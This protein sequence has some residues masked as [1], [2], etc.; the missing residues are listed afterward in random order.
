MSNEL[1]IA[2]KKS[3]NSERLDDKLEQYPV[4]WLLKKRDGTTTKTYLDM[5][6]KYILCMDKDHFNYTSSPKENQKLSDLLQK[7]EKVVDIVLITVFQWFGS[8]VGIYKIRNLL[9]GLTELEK[10]K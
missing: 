2:N 9:K 6:K 5:I 7:N 10:K 3:I 8:N 1:K 4:I